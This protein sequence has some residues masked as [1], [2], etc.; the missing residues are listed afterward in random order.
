MTGHGGGCNCHR[1][2]LMIGFYLGMVWGQVGNGGA[3]KT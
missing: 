2:C 3:P 1:T